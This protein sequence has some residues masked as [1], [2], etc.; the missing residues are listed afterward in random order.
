M[1]VT[2]IEKNFNTLY[3]Q[4]MKTKFLAA[5]TP[6]FGAKP[7]EAKIKTLVTK[8]DSLLPN[9]FRTG[10]VTPML[11]RADS[12]FSRLGADTVSVETLTGCV[13][14]HA[15]K[16]IKPELNRFLAVIS[17][18]YLSFLNKSQRKN[19]QIEL[20]ETLPPLAVYQS[21]ATNGPFTITCDMVNRLTGGN[22]GVVS[23]P[24][25]FAGHPLFY[26]SLAHETGGHDVIH[27]DHGLMQQLRDQ[28]YLLFPDSSNQ[29]QA[30]LWD[31]WMEEA[32]ADTYGVL[33]MGPTFAFNLA[34]LLAVFIGQF[35]SPPAKKPALRN[36][37]GADDNNALDV[38]PTDLLRLALVQGIIQALPGLSPSTRDSYVNQIAGLSNWLANGATTIELTGLAVGINGKTMNFQKAYPIASMQADARKVGAMIATA[39]LIA[40]GGHSIQD[41]ETWDDADE[42]AAV[43]IAGRMQA[44]FPVVSGGDD[45]QLLA[46]LTLAALQQP[47]KYGAFTKMTNDALDNS[48]ANDPIWGPVPRDLMV[49]TPARTLKNPE[50]HV[51]PYAEKIIDYN[52]LD[53]DGALSFGSAAVTVTRHAI[54]PIPWPQS[55]GPEPD[56]SFTYNGKDAV[57]PPA[58]FVIFTWTSAEANAMA[59]A[60]TPGSWAMPPAG[61]TGGWNVYANQWDAKYAGRFTP[62]SPAEQDPFVGKFMP[63]L[64]GGR[65]VLLFKSNFHLARDNASMPVKDMFKQ[66][67]E[68]TQAKLV[69]TS[70]TAGAI[71][72]KLILGDVVIAN[73]ARFKLDG[74]FKSIPANNQSFSSGYVVPTNGQLAGISSL[75]SPNVP[76][77]KLAHTAYPTVV[78]TFARDPQIFT[79]ANP[80][81][82]L[83]EPA[84]I[85]T[86]DK[87][88]FDNKQNSFQLQGLGAMIEMDDAVL[89]MAVQ[90]MGN[91]T[92]W[93]AIRNASDP[94][95]PTTNAGV[96]SAIYETYGYWTSIVSALASWACVVDF[97][98]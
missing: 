50:V 69:I 30:V 96:S 1:S 73:T 43:K 18:L 37:S 82:Q 88:E 8:T 47:T 22:V 3:T 25:T 62:R 28:C 38:H 98:G 40:L 21:V 17:D 66:V 68:Q 13:Y 91:P 2:G 44:N 16:S 84:V 49:I 14:Q 34:I 35:S 79:A 72:T 26:G 54:S 92:K 89:G 75:I 5:A 77:I 20:T 67:I 9:P 83:G 94:Q 70:G 60:L 64:I 53:E 59:A 90:E 71:G 19:L 52:P 24:A 27:A 80:T 74:T 10:Y 81:S 12:V 32:A 42:N 85:V 58:D 65:K 86:T 39:Q 45:A 63:I 87:F 7:T 11:D 33:N 61:V 95:M 29:W 57:L 48:F 93:L 4:L 56:K 55:L 23:M 15:D 51:D 31:Y 36:A 6:A 41:I 78:K 46:G 97:T 76:P